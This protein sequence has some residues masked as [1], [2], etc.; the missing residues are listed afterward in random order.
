LRKDLRSVA[1]DQIRRLEEAMVTRRRWTGAEF[2]RLLV[3]HPLMQHL[4]Q[5]LVWVTYPADGA[6]GTALRVAED[7][8]MADVDDEAFAVGDDDVIGVAH[9]LDLGADLPAWAALLIDYEILQPFP[10]LH[11]PVWRLTTEQ[12][13]Q[14]RLP[15]FVDVNVPVDRLLKLERRGWWRRSLPMA[16]GIQNTMECNLPGPGA[17]DFPL[18]PGISINDAYDQPTQTL[19]DARLTGAENF[20]ALDP[21]IVSELLCDLHYLVDGGPVR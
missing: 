14:Q 9:P 12:A 20:A 21:V 17:L 2:R 4:A 18:D 10:Q 1:A 13:A 7:G 11:R 16:A 19:R 15:E 5:R 8:S 6:A 3:G